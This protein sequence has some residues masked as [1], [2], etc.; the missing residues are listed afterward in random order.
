MKVDS[1]YLSGF[2][3]FSITEVVKGTKQN[4]V[5]SFQGTCDQATGECKCFNGY[6]S[7]NGMGEVGLRADCGFFSIKRADDD[8]ITANN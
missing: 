3:K 6:S 2:G 7:S 5:C 8:Y 1:K 4:Q